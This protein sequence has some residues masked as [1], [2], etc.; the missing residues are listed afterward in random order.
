MLAMHVRSTVIQYP[1][2]YLV[3]LHK[4]SFQCTQYAHFIDT[5][6]VLPARETTARGV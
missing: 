6:R 4:Q 1:C 5:R 3:R 2:A